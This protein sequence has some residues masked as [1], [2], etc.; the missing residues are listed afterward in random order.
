MGVETKNYNNP[1]KRLF[2][3]VRE[4][5][6]GGKPIELSIDGR[7]VIFFK[8]GD[9][10]RWRSGEK[11]GTYSNLYTSLGI[12]KTRFT[13]GMD[14]QTAIE[15]EQRE[16]D[17][18]EPIVVKS[19]SIEGLRKSAQRVVDNM[20]RQMILRVDHDGKSGMVR[21]RESLSGNKDLLDLFNEFIRLSVDY[22]KETLKH[23]GVNY[24][25]LF[26]ALNLYL[27]TDKPDTDMTTPETRTFLERI[28]NLFQAK[29]DST[30][31]LQ[32]SRRLKTTP[33]QT[34]IYYLSGA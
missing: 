25:R 6:S 10:I 7:M 21:L 23:N 20:V 8:E 17:K 28:R 13:F 33:N 12:D 4:K 3:L 11:N 1:S 2:D 30:F 26:F 15:S 29:N 31:I 5:T 19:Y 27:D 14:S 16:S 32:E 24:E 34:L 9:V 18:T 22:R